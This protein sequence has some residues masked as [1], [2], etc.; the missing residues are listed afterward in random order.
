MSSSLQYDHRHES[1]NTNFDFNTQQTMGEQGN[2]HYFKKL[3]NNKP[4][5]L[6]SGVRC[7]IV[8]KIG[9]SVPEEPAASIFRVEE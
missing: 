4:R 7:Y 1:T 8:Q 3:I 5:S 6:S 9:T 2:M